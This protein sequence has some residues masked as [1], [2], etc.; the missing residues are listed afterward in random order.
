[1]GKGR[2]LGVQFLTAWMRGSSRGR[3][4][5]GIRNQRLQG[6]GSRWFLALLV[7][8]LQRPR[9]PGQRSFTGSTFASGSERLSARV[10]V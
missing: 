3:C 6:Q 8:P 10:R 1:M 7:G 5:P 4:C 2:D 9:A